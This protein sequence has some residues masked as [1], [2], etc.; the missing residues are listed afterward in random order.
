MILQ[1]KLMIIFS[2]CQRVANNAKRQHCK[3]Y[4]KTNQRYGARKLG[5]SISRIKGN[6]L[7][8]E[9]CIG[10]FWYDPVAFR[11]FFKKQ[12]MKNR[13]KPSNRPVKLEQVLNQV[14]FKPKAKGM[15]E[16]KKP[17]KEELNTTFEL[18]KKYYL[19]IYV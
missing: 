16:N 3:M 7:Y 19:R 6:E 4:R 1:N 10:C 2:H 15:Y 11:K 5:F 18:K 14:F 13:N 8:N 9:T 12:T 17:S